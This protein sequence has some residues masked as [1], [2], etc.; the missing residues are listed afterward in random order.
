M[1]RI[2]VALKSS[3]RFNI[4]RLAELGRRPAQDNMTRK[5]RGLFNNENYHEPKS[6]RFRLASIGIEFLESEEVGKRSMCFENK[7]GHERK[8]RDTVCA[9]E[10]LI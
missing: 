7:D 6:K 4:Q 10:S 9:S 1:K 2:P 3:C 5:R 8:L